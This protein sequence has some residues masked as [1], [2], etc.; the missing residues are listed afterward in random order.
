[1][2]PRKFEYFAPTTVSEAVS[3]LRK[4]RDS[5]KIL[6]G[7]MSLI[8]MMK[9]RVLSPQVIIDINN[10]KSLNYI[11]DGGK[12]VRIGA[13]VRHADIEHSPIIK[14]KFPMMADA[15]PHIADMQ[16]RNLGTFL[17]ALAHADPA[18]D[19]P[20]SALALDAELVAQGT[21]KR[22]IKATKFFKGPFETALKPTEMLV[23][24]VLP[25]PR[26]EKVGQAYLKFERKAGDYA[27]VGV[28]S[29]L[30]LN[31][32]NV[33]QKAAIAL[34]AVNPFPFRATDAEELLVGQKPSKDLIE[35]AAKAAAA[36]ADPS[37]DLRGSAEYKRE[38]AKVFTRRSLNR[39]LER[40]GVAV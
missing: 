31:R 38:M 36:M 1:M 40:A 2:I 18:A 11:K 32:E 8:P 28:A 17:G 12:T 7:G 34:T 15:A 29:L 4:Y 37:S 19:W 23:E 20:A 22:V 3:L 21:A 9:L 27:I 16:V 33:I 24:A 6:S 13:L 35:Q 14:E 10:I 30:T 26:G 39:A 5:A 25:V